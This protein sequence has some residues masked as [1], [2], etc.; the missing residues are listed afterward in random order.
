MTEPSGTIAHA[1]AM[2][3][4]QN[5]LPRESALLTLAWIHYCG[6]DY[7]QPLAP[8]F[9]EKFRA[10]VDSVAGDFAAVLK[11]TGALQDEEQISVP[12]AVKKDD[13]ENFV[14]EIVN[15]LG[16]HP[17]VAMQFLGVIAYAD[18]NLKKQLHLPTLAAHMGKEAARYGYQVDL[19]KV[20]DVPLNITGAVQ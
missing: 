14:I 2:T 3:S 19:Q 13:V 18:G 17:A 1:V 15:R 5:K 11:E 12:L 4:D 7:N 9:I 6:G 10:S 20:E 8:D 16:L